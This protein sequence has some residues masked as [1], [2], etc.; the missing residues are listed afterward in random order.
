M[1]QKLFYVGLAAIA[2]TSCSTDEVLDSSNGGAIGFRAGMATRA[3][4]TTI[5]NLSGFFV[6]AFNDNKG[7]APYFADL[8]FTPGQDGFF[9]SAK[10]YY[11]PGDGTDLTFFAYAPSKEELG[12]T[13][14]F[15]KDETTGKLEGKLV[16]FTPAS[17]I[18]SQVDFITAMAKGN[19]NDQE[20]GVALT[21]GH[22]LSQVGIQ[23]KNA[24]DRYDVEVKGYRIGHVVSSGDYDFATGE[25]DLHEGTENVTYTTY[26][27]VLDSATKLTADPFSLTG[28]DCAMIIPQTLGGW[29]TSDDKTNERNHQYISFL[30]R[31]TTKAGAL[32][33]P[34]KGDD[35][36]YAWVAIPVNTIMEPGV[37]Y[38]YT[39]DFAN[40]AGWVDPT[41][42][43]NP[44]EY[45][46]DGTVKFS[47]EV[48]EWIDGDEDNLLPDENESEDPFGDL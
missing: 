37:R 33:Y 21:F 39:M 34:F 17:D 19:K 30:V 3:T 43:R 38:L 20:T 26:E 41:E 27:K 16:G 22:C 23:C 14:T 48:T 24:N 40:G 5:G 10:S 28:S 2:L 8:Q 11:Y 31:I 47:V 9:E 29:V 6:T 46:L 15:T 45:V 1:K 4:E 25:W 36:E 44:G 13:L 7:D 42:E 32:V 12:G 35:R 18:S